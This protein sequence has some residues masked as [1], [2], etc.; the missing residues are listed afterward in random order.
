MDRGALRAVVP[1]RLVFVGLYLTAAVVAWRFGLSSLTFLGLAG[2]AGAT[3]FTNFVALRLSARPQ[4]VIGASVL[5]DIGL[6]TIALG[7]TGGPQNPFSVLY[8]VYVALAATLLEVFWMWLAVFASSVGFALLF[9]FHLP[10]PSAG[11]VHG[12]SFSL[13]MQGMWLA[14]VL[15]AVAIVWF[16]ARLAAEL[17]REREERA[18]ATQLLALATLAA[19]AAHEIGNPLGTIRIATDELREALVDAKVDG[20]VLEDVE[21]IA[22]E[23]ARAR[24]VLDRMAAGAV[25]LDAESREARPLR[26]IVAE[27]AAAFGADSHRIRLT[28]G[29][30]L[31]E[32]AWPRAVTDQALLQ[33]VRN[34]LQ[35]SDGPVHIDVAAEEGWVNFKVTDRGRGMAAHI[36]SKST[37]PFFTTRPE[38]GV[39]LGLFIARS[40]I[41]HLGG[42]LRI[43]SVVSQGT[44]VEVT[45]PA[46][47]VS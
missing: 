24:G 33:L 5:F 1:L 45:L 25:E 26:A 23:V 28:L 16:V 8:V 32:V 2:L 41:E 37:E 34:A 44:T 30:P 27:L 3:A 29:E 7:L 4:H 19:G 15:A 35:A 17:R 43:D 20:D 6:L 36:L 42:R 46:G 21:L 38:E 40:L 9:A 13:H 18:R 14:Y 47:G 11:H 31:P 12:G 22:H 10:L 39:G